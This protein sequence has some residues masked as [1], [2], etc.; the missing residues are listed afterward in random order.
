MIRPSFVGIIRRSR[1]GLW[2]NEKKEK[3][4]RVIKC[5]TRRTIARHIL[6]GTCKLLFSWL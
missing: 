5:F 4:P 2:A 3:I 6:V 1:G